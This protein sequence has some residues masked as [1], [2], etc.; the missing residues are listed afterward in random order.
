MAASEDAVYMTDPI[1]SEFED[2]VRLRAFELWNAEGQVHGLDQHYWY[3]AINLV[4][5]ETLG[6]DE[7]WYLRRYD[8]VARAVA[9]GRCKSGYWHYTVA[10]KR[11]RRLPL[12]PV[13]L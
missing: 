5:I 8:D 6:F 13:K 2:K 4:N 9:E 11:E 10:G 1:E 3:K 12:E 7:E